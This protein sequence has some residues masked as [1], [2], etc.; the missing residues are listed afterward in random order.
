M[1][2]DNSPDGVAFANERF[3]DSG[4]FEYTAPSLTWTCG[5]FAS[6]VFVMLLTFI[7]ALTCII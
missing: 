5:F 1:F 2:I 4:S 6:P 3:S 7:F